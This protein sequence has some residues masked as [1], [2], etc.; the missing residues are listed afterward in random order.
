MIEFRKIVGGG[1]DATNHAD[2]SLQEQ[3]LH[4]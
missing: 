2:H 3:R 4:I 1:G